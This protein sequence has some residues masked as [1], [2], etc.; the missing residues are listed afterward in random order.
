MES[1]LK[2]FSIEV[3]RSSDLKTPDEIHGNC[4]VISSM[5]TEYRNI[6]ESQQRSNAH[7]YI[8]R[9][10]AAEVRTFPAFREFKLFTFIVTFFIILLMFMYIFQTH[11]LIY[12]YAF[13]HSMCDNFLT[14][15]Q[16]LWIRI[17]A[18]VFANWVN[19]QLMD[20]KLR[21]NDIRTD[22]MDGVSLIALVEKVL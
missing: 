6:K 17:Q 11:T 19:I 7:I 14:T 15:W 12:R 5:H 18:R 22:F 10:M 1:I 3:K 16:P 13:T 2:M 4:E 9:T 21:I 8:F 20:K